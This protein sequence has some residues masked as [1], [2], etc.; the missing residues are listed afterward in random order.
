MMKDQNNT[1]LE[2]TEQIGGYRIL[3][4]AE[5]KEINGFY[6]ELIHEPT[7]ARHIHISRDDSENT[8]G[9]AFK[10]VPDDST[11]VAHIL[12]HTVLCGSKRFPV[13]DPFFSMLK[14]SLQTFM[15]AFTASDW[16][17]YPFSTQNKKDFYNLLDVYLDAAFHPNLDVLNF[18]QEGHRLELEGENLVYKGVVYNEM[19][20]AMSSPDQILVRTL[21]KSLYPDTTYRNNSGG[22]PAEIPRL[23]HAQLTAFHRR[24]YHPSNAFFYTYGNLPLIPH[25]NFIEER[26]LRHFERIDPKTDVPS[27]P[28]WSEPRKAVQYYPLTADE[29][30]ARKCQACLAWL[31]GDIRDTYEILVLSLLE[32]ILLGNPAS[33]L[34]KALIESGL[35]SALSD[36]TGLDADNRDAMFACGLKDIEESSVEAVERIIFNTLETLVKEGINKELIEAAIHQLEFRRKEIT[37]TPYPYGLKMLMAISGTWFHTGDPLRVLRLDDD[38]NQLKEAVAQGPFFENQIKK[39][40][41]ENTHRVRFILMPD[42]NMARKAAEQEAGELAGI[43][44]GL[45]PEELEQIKAD[46]EALEQ[47]QEAPEDLSVLPTLEISDIPPMVPTVSASRPY[48]P[49]PAEWYAQPASGIFYFT[50]VSGIADLKPGLIPLVPFFCHAFTKSG[51]AR[52]DYTEMAR[53]IDLYTGGMGLGPHARTRFDAD[54]GCLPFVTFSAKCLVRNQDRM[55]E[56]IRELLHD[57]NFADLPRLK[58]LMLEYRASLES[59]VVRNGHGLAISLASRNISLKRHLNE[60]WEGIHQLKMIKEISADMSEERLAALSQNLLAIA[61][62]LYARNNIKLALIGEDSALSRAVSPMQT[63]VENLANRESRGL[64]PPDISAGSGLL[65]EGWATSTAVSFVASAFEAVRMNHPD[66]PVLSVTAKMLRSL[67]LHREIREKG[68]AYGGFSSYTSEDGLF[69]FGSYRDPHIVNTL[70]VY[71]QAGDFIRSGDYTDEDVKEAIL[72]VCSEL[73]TPDPP[74]AAARKAFYR[75]LTGLTDE[76]RNQY[77]SRILTVTRDQ[78]QQAAETYFGP[79]GSRSVAVISSEDKLK[80][81]N[82]ELGEKLAVFKI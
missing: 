46:A 80:E 43:K 29:D 22:D 36:G 76:A 67:Y 11:G 37:N 53:L 23:T 8:F 38:L 52:R 73:D 41:L 82:G 14:R 55:F 68:G 70:K 35:G 3:R 64:L 74:H 32:K 1:Q 25:L 65:R 30:P 9:A 13:R 45:S 26:I 28:R 24:H 54:G 63:L 75:Q 39:Y 58:A 16:T 66:A 2:S 71:D 19:K 7:A 18:K 72:Q 10:T 60:T 48:G 20:G 62:G 17:M 12:E 77:K 51:T 4:R 44:Q 81:A 50:A 79:G 15:N 6:Y 42:Q 21:L 47:L 56:L 59:S 33:P 57:V 49:I 69:C 61:Q 40:F 27:Q 34:K 31:A 78:V 5:L